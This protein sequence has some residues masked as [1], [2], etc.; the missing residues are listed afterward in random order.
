[1]ADTL[2][3]QNV[4]R[5]NP[6]G[7]YTHNNETV[8]KEDFEARRAAST[9]A[10]NALRNEPT[11]GFEDTEDFVAGAKARAAARKKAAGKKAGGVIKSSASSRGDGCAQRGKTKGR[12]V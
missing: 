8:S 6:D 2:P 12:M 4:F 9:K 3:P 7:T 10:V 5:A 1:M 11:A